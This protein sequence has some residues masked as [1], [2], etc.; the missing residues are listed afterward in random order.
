[1]GYELRILA[2]RRGMY[3][4]SRKAPKNITNKGVGLR[5]Y[6]LLQTL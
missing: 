5:T 1:M 4:T 3:F 2:Q 6:E